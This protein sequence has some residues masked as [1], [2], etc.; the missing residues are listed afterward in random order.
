MYL[1]KFDHQPVLSR[2]RLTY[3]ASVDESG[4]NFGIAR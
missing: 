1:S 2:Y 3:A 4:P